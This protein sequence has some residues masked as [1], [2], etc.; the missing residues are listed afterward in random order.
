MIL[1]TSGTTANPKGCV[2]SHEAMVRGPLHRALHR[3]GTGNADVTW[4][5]GPLYHVGC[6]SP[7]LGSIGAG[8]TYLTDAHFDPG[9]AL[10]LMNAE[11]ANVAFPWFPAIMQ[12]LRL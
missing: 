3:F 10:Q 5:A 4:G 11:K 2:L 9:R 8:G 12:P 6:L 1:Y 7:F